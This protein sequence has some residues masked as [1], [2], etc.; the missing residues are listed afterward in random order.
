[1]PGCFL[2]P[3][4]VHRGDPPCPVVASYL[5]IGRSC[6]ADD[7]EPRRTPKA[8][9][10]AMATVQSALGI[11]EARIA[12]PMRVSDSSSHQ[13]RDLGT[14]QNE[15]SRLMSNELAARLRQQPS[16]GADPKGLSLA[17][18]NA[19]YSSLAAPIYVLQ[20]ILYVVHL[21]HTRSSD[22][23]ARHARALSRRRCRCRSVRSPTRYL[24]SV[25]PASL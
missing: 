17:L 25:K 19:T 6:I 7:G 18:A 11:G 3:G 5:R 1:M 8:S 24:T 10:N 12:S 13:E 2:C 16:S 4:S 21:T 14:W 20:V 9:S 22:H 23:D 15:R